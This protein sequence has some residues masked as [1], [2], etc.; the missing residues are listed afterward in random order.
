L[1]A[2]VISIDIYYL[3][4]GSISIFLVVFGFFYCKGSI[5]AIKQL[6]LKQKNPVY[7]M[8]GEMVSSL[9]QIKIFNRRKTLIQEFS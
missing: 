7:N 2:N 1:I 3:I 9:I 6:D 5:I 4:P 8:V